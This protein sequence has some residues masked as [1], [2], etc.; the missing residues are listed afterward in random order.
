MFSCKEIT[1]SMKNFFSMIFYR[2]RKPNPPKPVPTKGKNMRYYLNDPSSPLLIEE[3]ANPVPHGLN[4]AVANLEPGVLDFTSPQG[5]A[6]NTYATLCHGINMFNSD[7]NLSKWALVNVLN[8]NPMAGFEANAY[9]DRRN[10]KFFYFTKDGK[11]VFTSLSADVISHELGHALLDALRPDMFNAASMEVWAF[12]EAFGDIN[13]IMC[14]LY[15]NKIVD[16]VLNETNGNL[17]TPNIVSRIGEEFG[18]AL[19]IPFSL[20]D[21]ANNYKYQNPATLPANSNDHN[22]I[23]R[24]PHSFSKIMSGIFYDVLCSIYEKLGKDKN[25]LLAARDYVKK[26]FYKACVVAPLAPTFYNS[27]CTAWLQ[28]DAKLGGQHND[29]LTRVFESRNVFGVKGMSMNESTCSDMQIGFN[30]G[31]VLKTFMTVGDLMQDELMAMADGEDISNMKVMLAVDPTNWQNDMM[32]MQSSEDLMESAKNAA[33]L[34]L[35]YIFAKRLFGRAESDVWYKD[36]DN[37]LSRRMFQCDCFKPNYLFPGNPEY[38]KPYKPENN[39]GC[40][41]YGSCAN[42][43]KPVTNKIEKNCNIRYSNSCSS[44][45]YRGRC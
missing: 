37:K 3:V 10:L 19:N 23:C 13:A 18:V 26:T 16:F 40:C 24:E 12:H 22:V 1:N 7:F 9:Y 29:V 27:F 35:E 25:A 33:K 28:E 11:K 32:Q 34:L 20:R 44:V 38:N 21:A 6:N 45:A 36:S 2:K 41:T 5:L 4:I 14:S 31:N 43:P 15:H 30:N 42:L 8:V 17:R 39:S